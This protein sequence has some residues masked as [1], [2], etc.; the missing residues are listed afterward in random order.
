[1]STQLVPLPEALRALIEPLGG[2]VPRSGLMV[3]SVQPGTSADRGGIF[4]GD[5]LVGL[6]GDP[7][8]DPRDVFA[9]LGPDTV[10]RE[11]LATIVRA[12]QPLT[13]TLTIDEH[14]E[15]G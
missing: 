2:R 14:P 11:M 6:G 12:G 4:L 3:V 1:V 7:M 5:L 8:E 9:A 13:V 15:R 10:G